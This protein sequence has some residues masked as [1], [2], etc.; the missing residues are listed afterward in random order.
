M[1]IKLLTLL[2]LISCYQNSA[3]Q[4]GGQV[5]AD[6]EVFTSYCKSHNVFHVARVLTIDGKTFNLLKYDVDIS[7]PE[8]AKQKQ[9]SVEL[10]TQKQLD[11]KKT[12]I[13]TIYNWIPF[14][15]SNILFVQMQI[16]GFK[17]EMELLD[18][19]QEIEV[20]LT[21]KLESK[22]LGEWSASDLG[23]GGSNMLFSVTNVENALD[24][25]IQL[26]KQNN[27]DKNVLI[28]RRILI[29]NDEWFYEVIYPTK[30]SGDFNTM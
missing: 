14:K 16:T 27:L 7:T 12:D 10:L 4:A 24:T 26:L 21:S 25:I 9:I 22:K 13:K 6:K 5:S 28:G 20:K 15:G 1:G 18:K 8:K 19:R 29:N 23:P 2:A 17:N 11:T 30:Y 3:N